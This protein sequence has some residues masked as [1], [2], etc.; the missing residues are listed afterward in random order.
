[1]I[2]VASGK[3][4]AANEF[5]TFHARCQMQEK[6]ATVSQRFSKMT[7]EHCWLLHPK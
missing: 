2:K 3:T 4:R 5:F 1:M 7:S 6:L